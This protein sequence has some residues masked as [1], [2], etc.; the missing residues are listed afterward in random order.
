MLFACISSRF[1]LFS[2]LTIAPSDCNHGDK[3]YDVSTSTS[4]ASD[5]LLTSNCGTSSLRLSALRGQRLNVSIIDFTADDA[6]AASRSCVNYFQLRDDVTDDAMTV[7]AGVER[8]RH[9]LTSTGNELRI[10][11]HLHD[12]S[13]QKFLLQLQGRSKAINDVAFLKS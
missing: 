4:L 10:T 2:A 12:A 5:Q 11:F 6:H 13:K 1:I 3:I 8:N 9:V 7:C